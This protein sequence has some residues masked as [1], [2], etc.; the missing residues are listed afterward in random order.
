MPPPKGP[1]T[2]RAFT[3]RFSRVALL[4]TLLCSTPRL[5][6]ADAAPAPLVSDDESR[7]EELFR[8]GRE[9]LVAERF[10]E[11][12]AKL[13]S[14]QRLE[15]R[16]GTLLNIAVCQERLAKV[17]TAWSAFHEARAKALA[18]GD[19]ERATFAD[20]WLKVLEPRLSWLE[21]QGPPNAT[22]VSV[23]V[24]SEPLEPSHW[25]KERPMNAGEHL[26]AAAHNGTEYWRSRVE[27][28]E[29]QHVAVAIPEPPLPVAATPPAP[30]LRTPTSV[31][32]PTSASQNTSRPVA[33][34][35]AETTTNPFVFEVGIMAGLVGVSTIE[36]KPERNPNDIAFYEPAEDGEAQRV[37]C[38]TAICTYGSPDGG[39]VVLAATGYA[40][41]TL[42]DWTSLGVR[43]HVGLN[44]GGGLLLAGGPS[45]SLRLGSRFTV[46]PTLLFGTAG[47]SGPAD[48]QLAAPSGNTFT[49]YGRMHATTQF[50]VGLGVALAMDVVS[51]ETGALFVNCSPLFIS[52]TN[53]SAW[54][55][56]LGVG[57]RWR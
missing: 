5:W 37:S 27:L 26:L 13:D 11:A 16:V 46:A 47:H 38:G 36:S 1:V 57:Y 29:S 30:P 14:S 43:A 44:L 19:S 7:A 21:V 49:Y 39:A 34:A 17:A 24:D 53:G 12:C 20:N 22:E 55:V 51:R 6:A 15:P 41:Y 40:G 18:E 52:G 54:L 56:P 10:A 50:A 9:L 4:A 8:E 45:F 48:A 3:F 42:S 35:S 28:R 31:H 2:L 32:T 23:S 33:A 25:A